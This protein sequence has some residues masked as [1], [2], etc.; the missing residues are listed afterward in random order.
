MEMADL[1]AEVLR[2]V[3]PHMIDAAVAEFL[4]GKEHN[5]KPSRDYDLLLE[6]GERLPPKAVFGL[7][8][9]KVIGRPATPYDFS[10]GWGAPCFQSSRRLGTPLLPKARRPKTTTLGPKAQPGW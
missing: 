2:R 9:E 1:P 4:A 3:Q 6:T 7:A 8:L 5:F 10:A